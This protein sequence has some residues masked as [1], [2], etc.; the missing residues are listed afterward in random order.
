MTTS[1]AISV[2]PEAATCRARSSGPASGSSGTNAAFGAMSPY[3]WSIVLA[4]N[5]W[6]TRPCMAPRPPMAR[7]PDATST[8]S[9]AR[10][11]PAG[12]AVAYTGVVTVASVPSV[13]YVVPTVKFF[14]VEAVKT[15]SPARPAR[16]TRPVSASATE[17][18]QRAVANSG[19]DMT[20]A[21][22][23][24]SSPTCGWMPGA[25]PG[26]ADAVDEVAAVST[27]ADTSNGSAAARRS[28]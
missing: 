17:Y 14:A 5:A 26:A 20:A 21:A 13:A 11:P 1:P 12:W 22:S 6:S 8:R 16:T 3:T 24:G 4:V 27:T 18:S 9:P 15:N 7:S 19:F 10:T 23:A 25:S 2:T 28:M